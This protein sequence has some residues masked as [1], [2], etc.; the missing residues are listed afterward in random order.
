MSAGEATMKQRLQPESCVGE[1]DLLGADAWQECREAY[2]AY[3]AA[4]RRH[5]RSLHDALAG[6]AV[7]GS[8]GAAEA[9]TVARELLVAWL[10]KCEAVAH[11]LATAAAPSRRMHDLAE[12]VAERRA[13]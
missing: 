3:L 9:G 10:A 4:S 13:A 5:S 8:A 11:E 12:S 7:A 2:W 1:V 6:D